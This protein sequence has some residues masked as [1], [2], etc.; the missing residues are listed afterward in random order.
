MIARLTLIYFSSFCSAKLCEAASFVKLSSSQLYF[1]NLQS[2]KFLG[3]RKQAPPGLTPSL[4][5]PSVVLVKFADMR[6]VPSA[7][8]RNFCFNP[9]N[10]CGE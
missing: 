10:E 8:Y 3:T 6:A 9:G 5:R 2:K 1:G 4:V 7:P